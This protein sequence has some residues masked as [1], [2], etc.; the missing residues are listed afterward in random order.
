MRRRVGRAGILVAAVMTT[1]GAASAG[2][3]PITISFT[4]VVTSVS[5][6]LTGAFAVNDLLSG[7]YTF[8]STTAPRAGSNSTFAVFDAITDLIFTL[9]SYSAATA[10]SAPNGEVQVDND[11][12][13]P[14][15]D[16][17]GIVSRASD[18]LAGADVNGFALGAFGFRLDDASNSV[19]SDALILPAS[20]NLSDF[21]S[22]SFFTFYGGELV[23]GN[24]TSARVVSNVPEPATL[25]LTMLGFA[26][27]AR[28]RFRR[29]A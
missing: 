23:S 1:F 15:V 21:T 2:A 17:Y 18:G 26:V 3:D 28:R 10:G 20:V 7:S 6:G 14:N 29:A 19:Y 25:G 24:L 8:E 12:P 9:G 4:G 5:S 13:F 22:S 11:P 16:R 27:L